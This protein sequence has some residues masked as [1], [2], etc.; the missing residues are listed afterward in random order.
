MTL[1]RIQ[2]VLM[3]NRKLIAHLMVDSGQLFITD[4]AYLSSW[5]HGEYAKGVQPD[6]S[7]ARVTTFMFEHGGYG[8][9]ERGVVVGTDGDG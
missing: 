5:T 4:P 9:V 1:Y 3:M 6:N 2:G 8:E 7:Y